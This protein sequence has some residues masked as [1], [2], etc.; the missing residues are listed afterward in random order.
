MATGRRVPAE[1]GKPHVVGDK[2][3]VLR[4]HLSG[5]GSCLTASGRLFHDTGFGRADYSQ[6]QL[7][8][9]C[10]LGIFLHDEGEQWR[11]ARLEGLNISETNR[12]YA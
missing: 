1:G 4:H 10:P 9:G 3:L 5:G 2:L 8:R 12:L 11:P 7:I 6:D